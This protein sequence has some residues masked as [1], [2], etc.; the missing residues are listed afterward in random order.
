MKSVAVIGY[1]SHAYVAIDAIQT[2]KK[3]V[4]AYFEFEAK[5]L[6]PY[7]LNYQGEDSKEK[8]KKLSNQY[9]FF[10]GIG[11]N[12]IRRK[13]Y[14]I[15]ISIDFINAI[16][17]SAQIGSTIKFGKGVL[18]GP[19][20]TVNAL[21]KIGNGVICN[22]GSIIE[23]E[24]EIGDFA[25]IAPGAVLCGNVEIGDNTFIGANTVVKQGI[26]IGENVVIGAGS[27]VTRD[28]ENNQTVVGNPARKI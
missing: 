24:C 16:H 20:V 28:I 10:I 1:S 26:R 4:T 27:V 19:N 6:N 21:S 7:D 17:S 14:E 15:N 8:L 3:E 18:V 22:S 25:H 9:D 5:K 23:H 13:I 12:H 11:E 2:M